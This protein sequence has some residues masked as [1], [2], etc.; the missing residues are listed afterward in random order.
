MNQYLIEKP[1]CVFLLLCALLAMHIPVCAQEND[2]TAFSIDKHTMTISNF[3]PN[4][5]A[6]LILPPL[7]YLLETASSSP[8]VGALMATKEQEEGNLKTVKRNWMNNLYSFGNYQYGKYVANI[9]NTTTAGSASANATQYST[10]AQ[11]V[12]SIGIGLTL[13]FGQ[14]YN[15]K[16]TIKIQQSRLKQI[17]FEIADAVLEQ[18]RQISDIYAIAVQQLTMLKSQAEILALSNTSAKNAEIKY[19][20]GDIAIS[21]FNSIKNAQATALTS[22]EST[23]SELNRAILYLELL[24][25]VNIINK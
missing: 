16:N 15:R 3:T 23:R 22:Y 19:M 2:T 4:D 7:S 18:K 21:E 13:P 6:K 12:Y 14:I 1:V 17:D 10:Q 20:N 11:D 5:Y 24:T 8:K 9:N 25:G